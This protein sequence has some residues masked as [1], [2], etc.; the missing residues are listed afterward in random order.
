[1]LEMLEAKAVGPDLVTGH[2][3]NRYI[4]FSVGGGPLLGLRLGPTFRIPLRLAA[5]VL[6]DQ[7]TFYLQQGDDPRTR[8]T[9]NRP[10]RVRSRASV[11][12]A[13]DF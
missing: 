13:V 11:G 9:V 6:T 10:T 1:V 4:R 2:F 8:V 5:L 3:P 7:P 12:L